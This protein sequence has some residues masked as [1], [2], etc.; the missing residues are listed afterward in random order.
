MIAKKLLSGDLENLITGE[1]LSQTR[2]FEKI[3]HND[4]FRKTSVLERI[5]L[6]QVIAKKAAFLEKILI[7]EFREHPTYVSV[8][9]IVIQMIKPVAND[10]IQRLETSYTIVYSDF[11]K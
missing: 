4:I 8:R 1:G 3:H 5:S 7:Q 9:I 2:I 11:E 6:M 10:D